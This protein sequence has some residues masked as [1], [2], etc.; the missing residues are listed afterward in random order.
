MGLVL[1]REHRAAGKEPSNLGPGHGTCA[2]RTAAEA[3]RACTDAVA[4]PPAFPARATPLF[5]SGPQ[6]ANLAGD[7][8]EEK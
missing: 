3:G 7:V 1:K 5:L 4:E 8:A 6:V 2:A